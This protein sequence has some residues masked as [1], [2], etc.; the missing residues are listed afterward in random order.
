MCSEKWQMN[1]HSN[2]IFQ[3]QKL[4]IFRIS[5][6][7]PFGSDGSNHDHE[8]LNFETFSGSFVL[9]S[10]DLY[11]NIIGQNFGGKSFWRQRFSAP[12]QNFSSFVQYR[13]YHGFLLLPNISRAKCVLTSLMLFWCVQFR[14]TK[15][16]GRH[17]FRQPARFSTVLSSEIFSDKVYHRF[18]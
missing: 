18:C 2:I 15:L 11:F 1:V 14:W 16:F 6:I 12:T 3:E 10:L 5:Y 17:I 7:F 4:K 13:I 8:N 9:S